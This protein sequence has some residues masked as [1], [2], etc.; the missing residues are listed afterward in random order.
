MMRHFIN[1]LFI[2]A[3]LTTLQAQTARSLEEIGQQWSVWP[4]AMSTMVRFP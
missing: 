1:A 4:S 2:M 3:G